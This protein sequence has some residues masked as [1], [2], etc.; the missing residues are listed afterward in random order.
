MCGGKG[1]RLGLDVSFPREWGGFA[2][3]GLLRAEVGFFFLVL[4]IFGS[5]RVEW[6]W[7]EMHLRFGGTRLFSP[8]RDCAEEHIHT[9]GLIC[10]NRRLGL[11]LVAPEILR[12]IGNDAVGQFGMGVM[13]L[14][15]MCWWI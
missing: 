14:S 4:W 15:M 1:L 5:E 10:C 9:A 6:S 2:H 13:P 7:A 3:C 8:S 11:R 12:A